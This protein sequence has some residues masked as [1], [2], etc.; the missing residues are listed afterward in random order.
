MQH[1]H[2]SPCLLIMSIIVLFVMGCPGSDT[3]SETDG[4]DSG[5]VQLRWMTRSEAVTTFKYAGGILVKMI[6]YQNF[7]ITGGT[8]SI[9][10]NGSMQAYDSPTILDE[11][12]DA[13]EVQNN[14]AYEAII[15]VDVSG[16][17]ACNPG[18]THSMVSVRHQLHPPVKSI[19]FLFSTQTRTF[20][21][22]PVHTVSAISAFSPTN[23]VS[24]HG[25][26]NGDSG[27]V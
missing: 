20:L 12:T 3:D 19:F 25:S 5:N 23:A 22:A 16:W 11:Q 10:I 8:G 21:N 9:Q 13:F 7:L 14:T 2:A 15:E 26:E 6:F 27:S 1:S 24:N 4:S 17:G 18:F